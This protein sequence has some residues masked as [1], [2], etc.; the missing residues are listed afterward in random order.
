MAITDKTYPWAHRCSHGT[1]QYKGIHE[2]TFGYTETRK[3]VAA[4]STTAIHA[5]ATLAAAGGTISTSFTAPDVPRAVSITT[6]GTTGD[7]AAGQV[8]IH[9]TNVEGKVIHEQLAL[10]ANLSGTVSGVKAFKTVTS[11]DYPPMDGAAGTLAVGYLNKLGINHRLPSSTVEATVKVFSATT[12]GGALTLQN[13]PT[14][15]ADEADVEQNTVTP[16]TTPNGTTFLTICYTYDDWATSRLNDNPTYWDATTTSTS[17]TTATTTTTS[18]SSTSSS[19]SSTSSSTSST[20]S[21]TSSTSTSTTTV[22]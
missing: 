7:I 14:V 1:L 22:A 9:G 6:G 2:T 10:T 11:V 3:K 18:T 20:S 12:I 13:A 17:T 5:A 15:V 19:T 16:A 4:A 21:S 8:E